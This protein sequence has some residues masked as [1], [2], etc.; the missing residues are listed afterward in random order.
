MAWFEEIPTHQAKSGVTHGMIDKLAAAAKKEAIE[1]EIPVSAER[2]KQ[3]LNEL[4]RRPLKQ[5]LSL[6]I[7]A[8]RARFGGRLVPKAIE[9]DCH[10]AAK[11]RDEAAHGHL[12]LG[13]D[14][15]PVFERAIYAVELICCLSMVAD[16]PVSSDNMIRAVHHPLMT[17]ALNAL[18]GIYLE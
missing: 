18:N 13:G 3:V 8:N 16:L 6:A 12:I 7:E 2:V 10:I 15:F 11:F 5:R 1:K 14:E 4:R 17:Y 9:A